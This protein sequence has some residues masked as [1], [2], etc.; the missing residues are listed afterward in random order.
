MVKENWNILLLGV[1]S[2]AYLKLPLIAV[3]TM[4][5][6]IAFVIAQRDI[7]IKNLSMATPEYS[8]SNNELIDEDD[9]FFS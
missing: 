9:E 6:I 8:T 1:I 5:V 2:I 4:A 7:Q 3:A